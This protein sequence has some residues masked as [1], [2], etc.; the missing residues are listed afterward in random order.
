MSRCYTHWV[1]FSLAGPTINFMIE[2][3]YKMCNSAFSLEIDK[4]QKNNIKNLSASN[5]SFGAFTAAALI[6]LSC[7]IV[8]VGAESDANSKTTIKAPLNAQAFDTPSDA[9]ESITVQ[10]ELSGDDKPENGLVIGY[11]IHRA[12]HPD[13][14][15][16]RIDVTPSGISKYKDSTAEDKKS[17]RYRVLTLSEAGPSEPSETD[18]A[19]SSVQTFNKNRINLLV[20][21][22][23]IS[24]TMIFYIQHLKSGKK[25][26]IRKIAG[27]EAVEEAIGRATEMGRPILFIP[28]IQDM[29]DIQ[30]VAGLTILGRIAKSIA[31]YDTPLEVPTSRSLVMTTA[32]ETVKEAYLAAGKPDAYSDDMVYYLTDAQFAYVAGVNGIMVRKKPATCFYMGSFFAE[33]LILAETGNDIG[34]IQ[35]AGTAQPAQLPFFVAACDYTLIGEEL[36]AASAYLSGEPKQLGSLKGQDMG[37]FIAMVCILIGVTLATVAELTGSE[38]F[39]TALV[40]FKSIFTVGA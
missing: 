13:G 28:G 16:K 15:F 38:V 32:R 25:T 36:F 10:W 29:N 21:S 34:A 6:I 1:S 18:I 5:F 22:I 14:Q 24:G 33:S 26:F 39:S 7:L 27:L 8:S 9:G 11:E 2:L 3:D 37:K 20:I 19:Q 17:Y 31:E 30:T 40:W 23:I 35:I 4:D 12:E